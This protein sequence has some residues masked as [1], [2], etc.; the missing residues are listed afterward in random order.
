MTKSKLTYDRAL[1]ELREIMEELQSDDVGLDELSSRIK[2]A[3]FLVNYC[4][5]KLRSVENELEN[6]L[7][8]EKEED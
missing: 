8:G 7:K 5:E 6:M 3:S 4:K 1:S 2:R